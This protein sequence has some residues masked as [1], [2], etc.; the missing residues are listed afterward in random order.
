MATQL[1]HSEVANETHL[2]YSTFTAVTVMS[3]L[4]L[5]ATTQHGMVSS[6]QVY[7]AQTLTYG[8]IFLLLI[9]FLM[10]FLYIMDVGRGI[11][12]R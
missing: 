6:N 7:P 2:D 5:S 12:V 11:V 3:V 10:C 8:N 9:P 4:C 1:A